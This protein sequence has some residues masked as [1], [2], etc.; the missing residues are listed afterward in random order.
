M[1]QSPCRE[2]IGLA[3]AAAVAATAI[4]CQ[5]SSEEEVNKKKASQSAEAVM[6]EPTPRA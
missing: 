5:R 4:G 2:L 1:P 3:L 6:R